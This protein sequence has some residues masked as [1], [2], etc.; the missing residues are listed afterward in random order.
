MRPL[1]LVVLLFFSVVCSASD[2]IDSFI[3]KLSPFGIW[4]NGIFIPILLSES[5]SPQQ[6]VTEVLSKYHFDKYSIV[7]IKDVTINS[8]KYSAALIDTNRGRKIMLV[9]YYG[10]SSGWWNKMFDAK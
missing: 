5:A 8:M 2:D 6:V 10:G 7:E 4:E 9:R 3:S 1:F